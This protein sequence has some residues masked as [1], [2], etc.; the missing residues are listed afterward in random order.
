M[1]NREIHELRENLIT[2]EITKNSEM[3]NA[4]QA[5]RQQRLTWTALDVGGPG[6]ETFG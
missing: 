1:V 3:G 5:S 2:A 6:A 4:Q